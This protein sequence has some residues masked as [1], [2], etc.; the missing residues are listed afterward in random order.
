MKTFIQLFLLIT[1]ILITTNRSEGQIIPKGKVLILNYKESKN[2]RVINLGKIN[3]KETRLQN[4]SVES[5]FKHSFKP[6]LSVDLLDGDGIH[7]F[8]ISNLDFIP[9]IK[10]GARI[11]AGILITI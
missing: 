11:K 10:V 4:F 5:F 7:L 1:T 3:R 9:T 6:E 2:A 8:T